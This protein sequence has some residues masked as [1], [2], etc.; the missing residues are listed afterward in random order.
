MDT[1][2]L[3]REVMK[4][5]IRTLIASLVALTGLA[6]WTPSAMAR[7]QI[8]WSVGI[9]NP[10]PPPIIGYSQPVP[11]YVQ[12]PPVYVRP[13]P[14]V[15]YQPYFVNPYPQPYYS[16]PRHHRHYGHHDRY[17]DRGDRGDRGGRGDRGYRGGRD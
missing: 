10:Y 2:F 8:T 14:L 4:T 17:G 9:G 16:E 7:D 5:A 1:S 15:Q 3:R 13:A 6:L 11:V 12:P